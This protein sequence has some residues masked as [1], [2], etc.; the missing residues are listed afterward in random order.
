MDTTE[1]EKVCPFCEEVF[2]VSD[3]KVHIG[4]NH[5]GIPLEKIETR[6]YLF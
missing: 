2:S 5:L 4:V 6:V 3:I 1:I